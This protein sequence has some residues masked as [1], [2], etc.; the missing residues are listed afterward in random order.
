MPTRYA[1][2]FWIVQSELGT[3]D[4]IAMHPSA[5]WHEIHFIVYDHYY[6]VRGG[7]QNDQ[8]HCFCDTLRNYSLIDTLGDIYQNIYF[9]I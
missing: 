2:L 7:V 9:W 6:I 4:L 5:P 1:P 8:N 3:L